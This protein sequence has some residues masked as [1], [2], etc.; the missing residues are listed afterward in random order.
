ML[1]DKDKY[2][3]G[4]NSYL[5][6]GELSGITMLV[7]RFYSNMDSFSEAETI[8]KMH[9][10]N[11][12][13]SRKKLSYFLCGWLGGWLG[14]PKLFSKNYGGI[15]IPDFHKHFAIGSAE[16]DAWLFCM[17]AAIAMQ[18]YQASFKEYLFTQLK[19]PA[20]RVK[21]ANIGKG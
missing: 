12:S 17:Q 19:V 11:L 14:G 15:N 9:P 2:G 10:R 8:R 4:E 7:D 21:L 13:E 5:A 20:E 18:P 1:T 6:A 3:E 16:R